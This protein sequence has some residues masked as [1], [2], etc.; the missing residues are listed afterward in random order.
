MGRAP[1]AP[2]EFYPMRFVGLVERLVARQLD[3]IVPAPAAPAPTPPASS[4]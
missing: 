4:P 3:E 1:L 2:T